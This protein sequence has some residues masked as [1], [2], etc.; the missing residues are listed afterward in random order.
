VVSGT[1]PANGRIN[2]SDDNDVLDA[3]PPPVRSPP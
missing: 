3:V 1:S 2:F